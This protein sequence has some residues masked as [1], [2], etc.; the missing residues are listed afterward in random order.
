MPGIAWTA[1]TK[2]QT[3][4]HLGA[5][6]PR[7]PVQE[8]LRPSR[9]I[10]QTSRERVAFSSILEICDEGP[11]GCR[12]GAWTADLLAALTDFFLTTLTD[13]LLTFFWRTFRKWDEKMRCDPD[14]DWLQ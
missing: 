1:G 11:L 5:A 6:P 3:F 8:G 4:F 9:L 7:P 14:Y 2:F 10:G 13:F 12:V